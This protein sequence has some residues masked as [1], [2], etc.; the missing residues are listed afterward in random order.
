MCEGWGETT[1]G[2]VWA[3]RTSYDELAVVRVVVPVHRLSKLMHAH[4]IM[5]SFEK[6]SAVPKD[7]STSIVVGYG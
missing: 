6:R 7:V 3:N 4:T 5:S 2:A 1:E